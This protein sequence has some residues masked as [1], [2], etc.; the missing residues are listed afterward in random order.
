M[1]QQRPITAVIALR[2]NAKIARKYKREEAS[3]LGKTLSA[4]VGCTESDYCVFDVFDLVSV[5]T[6]G[7]M[8][9]T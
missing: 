2:V 4:T 1:D 9:F 5:Q 7:I 8:M 3:S 6:L